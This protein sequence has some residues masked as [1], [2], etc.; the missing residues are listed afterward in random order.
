MLQPLVRQQFFQAIGG[1]IGDLR[2]HVAQI[3]KRF[4]LVCFAT[5]HQTVVHG[6]GLAAPVTADEQIILPADSTGTQGA[7]RQIVVNR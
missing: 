3:G 7:F 4:Y 6:G 5:G 1:V 2:Q